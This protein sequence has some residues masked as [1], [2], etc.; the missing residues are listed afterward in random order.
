MDFASQ[1]QEK[2]KALAVDMP[3]IEQPPAT[4]VIIPGPAP[5]KKND[6]NQWIVG[7]LVLLVF[8]YAGVF[9]FLNKRKANSEEFVQPPVQQQS[10]SNI[11]AQVQNLVRPALEQTNQKIEVLQKDMEEAQRRVWMLGL[12][13]NQNAVANQKFISK[14]D[15]ELSGNIISLDETWKLSQMPSFLRLSEDDKKALE[16]HI[17]N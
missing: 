8:L 15:P 5:V 2:V 10:N 13:G 6:S 3:V 4:P 7:G 16:K 1:V 9:Y 17:K 12:M 14:Y 11:I